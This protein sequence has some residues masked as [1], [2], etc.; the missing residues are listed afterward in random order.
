MFACLFLSWA[1]KTRIKQIRKYQ[2]AAGGTRSHR[3]KVQRSMQRKEDNAAMRSRKSSAQDRKWAQQLSLI[4][5]FRCLL[6]LAPCSAL[7]DLAPPLLVLEHMLKLATCGSWEQN[8]SL[9]RLVPVM[10]F[11]PV[12][13]MVVGYV[14]TL[15]D[16]CVDR[17]R[18][19][20]GSQHS[21]R[22]KCKGRRRTTNERDSIEV[23]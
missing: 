8:A 3:N 10:R 9:A 6:L 7:A 19:A 17:G 4:I 18:S 11:G 20:R 21:I 16:L 5:R 22:G 13:G 23:S 2:G 15:R 1:G 12:A 14:Q